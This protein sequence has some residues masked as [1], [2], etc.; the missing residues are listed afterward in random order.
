METHFFL[1]AKGMIKGGRKKRVE[2]V[3]GE[4]KGVFKD[5]FS[6]VNLGVNPHCGRGRAAGISWSVEEDE[7]PWGTGFSPSSVV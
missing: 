6:C 4:N 5:F 7:S 1:C 2:A 3:G